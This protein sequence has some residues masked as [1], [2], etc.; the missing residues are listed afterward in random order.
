MAV[1]TGSTSTRVRSALSR[2]AP[3]TL[4]E[5]VPRTLGLLDQFGFWGNLGV[6]LFGL[7]TASTVVMA[8]PD[9][10]LPLAG[11]ALA[12]IVGTAIGGAILGV[13]LMLGARTGAP[14]MVLLRGLLGAKAS[15]LPTVLN[16]LQNLGWGTFE[17]ILIAESLR[18]VLHDHLARWVCVLIAGAIT[19]ALTIRPLGAI[20]VI[21][22]YVTVLVVV[23]TVVL[24]IGLL[25]HPIPAVPHSSWRGFWLGVDAVVAVSISWVPLG[26]D[27]TRHAKSERSAFFGGFVGY[28]VTQ[29][30][31]Y[32]VGVVALLQ[33][34]SDPDSIFDLYLTL[35][36]GTAALVILVLR[37][38][39][40]SFAN[41][42]STAISIQ[43]LRPRWD[44]RVLTLV[45][46]AAIT[47]GALYVQ[48]G[49]YVNFLTLLGG[50]FVPMSG[51]LVAA[52][53]RTRGD[54]WDVSES[55]PTRPPMLLAWAVGFVAYQL[56]N[57]GYL[58]HWSDAWTTAGQHLHT[59]NHPWLSASVVSFAVAFVLALPFGSHRPARTFEPVHTVR[60]ER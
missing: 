22:K 35:P 8:L 27:Y 4:T 20:R 44:R 46:G 24:A 39:D 7:T 25:R 54:G 12:I 59:L 21:R 6:S 28:G 41:T 13:S 29:I 31:C 32:L 17:V 38:T 49:D 52:W 3:T 5:D 2:E 23:A 45:I 30:A 55:A 50:V 15:Y 11:A 19:T 34:L 37:E 1:D 47:V 48:I 14:A 51:V 57:P 53:A 56:I 60:A 9:S 26:A 42:Y 40:Q 10:P 16:V 18:S 58:A 43:N 33:V 36:L